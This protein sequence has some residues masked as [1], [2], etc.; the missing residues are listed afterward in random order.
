MGSA[1]C[2]VQDQYLLGMANA[3]R[4]RDVLTIQTQEADPNRTSTGRPTG[5]PDA[6]WT[7]SQTVRG[8][9]QEGGRSEVER[10]GRNVPDE[11]YTVIMRN[12][13]DLTNS[14][15][16]IWENNN[17]EVLR[18]QSVGKYGNMDRLRRVQCAYAGQP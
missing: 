9:V 6:Q 18:I 15:R 1:D 16:L 11:D 17:G 2:A 4:F 10:G 7:D 3:G 8:D 5:G 13:P 12:H 14:A